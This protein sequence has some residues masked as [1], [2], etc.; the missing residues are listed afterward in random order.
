MRRDRPGVERHEP[1]GAGHL[2]G[3]AERTERLAAQGLGLGEADL[4]HEREAEP[5]AGLRV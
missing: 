5:I 3:L 1:R 4:L 2:A